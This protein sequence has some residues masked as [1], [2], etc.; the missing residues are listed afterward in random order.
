MARK[1][2]FIT[3]TSTGF[4]RE[5]AIAA[6]GR[7]DQVAATARSLAALKPLTDEFG[8]LVYPIE[9]D[10][11]D[12]G[13]VDAAVEAAHQRFGALDI[14]V[15]NAGYGA[16]GAIEEVTEAQAR[17]QLETNVLGSLWVAKAVIPFLRA[18]CHGHIIQVSSIGGVLASP[19]LGIYNASK[20]AV[21][22]MTQAL[23]A[24]VEPFGIA[25]T[26]IEPIMYRG[27][28]WT[29]Y[30]AEPIPDYDAARA[31]M[32][33]SFGEARPGDTLA[34]SAAILE[35]VD[36]AR[37]PLRILFGRGG[38]DLIRAEY[39]RRL[40]EWQEWE[41]VSLSAQGN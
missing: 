10:V 7:G 40:D 5:W 14:V 28:D 12:K 18:Q 27:A 33:A 36:A 2:W 20:W 17:A 30:A 11:T 39:Q 41:Q 35:I 25:V 8:E 29:G 34:T 22:A 15:N 16:Y 21:E 37:P 19:T 13:A 24:E 1:T 31:A 4:G 38:L 9:L 32:R 3:G 26:L 23:A 6:A